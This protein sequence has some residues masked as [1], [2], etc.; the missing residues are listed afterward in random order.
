M[1]SYAMPM[2]DAPTKLKCISDT[3]RAKAIQ[4]AI[5][6]VAGWNVYV[7]ILS[8]SYRGTFGPRGPFRHPA[9][10]TLEIR[11]IDADDS[12]DAVIT[13]LR[14]V[15]EDELCESICRR[16]DDVAGEDYVAE[17]SDRRYS[18]GRA[19]RPLARISV[20]LALRELAC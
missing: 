2:S 17:V 9:R 12:P 18:P 6:D 16:L 13:V 1:P 14:G 20:L 7:D 11:T 19:G 10:L 5:S 4:S 8:S 3:E 15:P